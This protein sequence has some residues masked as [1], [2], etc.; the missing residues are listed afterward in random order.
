MA[1]NVNLQYFYTV[2]TQL[3]HVVKNNFL[4]LTFEPP[5]DKT[6]KMACVPSEAQIDQI[7]R[8]PH[9]ESLGP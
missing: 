8:C 2:K 6:N 5:H 9:E 4:F 3:W 7:L 1:T